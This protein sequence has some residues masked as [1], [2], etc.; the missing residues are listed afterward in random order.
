LACF[1]T[2][3]PSP[4]QTDCQLPPFHALSVLLQDMFFLK[5]VSSFPPFSPYSVYIPC[6][7]YRGE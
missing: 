1:H 3:A 6:N 2:P 7:L 4:H 5:M